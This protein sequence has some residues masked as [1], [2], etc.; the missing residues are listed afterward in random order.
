MSLPALQNND[1]MLFCRNMGFVVRRSPVGAGDDAQRE[2]R[3]SV[4]PSTWV[5]MMACLPA[6]LWRYW[7]SVGLSMK[8]FSVRTAGQSEFRRMQK[9]KMFFLKETNMHNVNNPATNNFFYCFFLQAV[10]KRDMGRQTRET[11]L[12][13]AIYAYHYA[14]RASAYKLFFLVFFYP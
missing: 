6:L 7:R 11:C 2:E 1:P 5:S 3:Y 12:H 13:M 4:M 14:R 10:D 8:K 9:P